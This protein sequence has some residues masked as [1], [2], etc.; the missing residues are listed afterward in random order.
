MTK[1]E[2]LQKEYRETFVSIMTGINTVE[3][4]RALEE[5]LVR[6]NEEMTEAR[7]KARKR[8]RKI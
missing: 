1:L 7:I 2:K 8:G 6:L 4:Q 5:K 3:E